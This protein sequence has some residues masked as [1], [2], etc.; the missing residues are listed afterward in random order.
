MES[1]DHTICGF[2][3][4]CLEEPGVVE[5]D[6]SGEAGEGGRDGLKEWGEREAKSW[7]GRSGSGWRYIMTWMSLSVLEMD[8]VRMNTFSISDGDNAR[9]S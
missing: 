6:T 7:S 3:R 4:S 8:W 1:I 2:E 9:G 5:S